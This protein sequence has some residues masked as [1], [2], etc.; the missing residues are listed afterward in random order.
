MKR[1]EFLLMVCV[2]VSACVCV[3]YVQ[4]YV[5]VLYMYVYMC[6]PTCIH[7]AC[8]RENAVSMCVYV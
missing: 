8:E 5:Y 7:V 4:V 2:S 3:G 1:N 6:G